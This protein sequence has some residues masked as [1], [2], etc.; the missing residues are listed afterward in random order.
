M[1]FGPWN[2][3]FL[4]RLVNSP[5]IIYSWPWG[6]LG[7]RGIYAR[8]SETFLPVIKPVESHSN[9]IYQGGTG[10]DWRVAFSRL[11]SS[12]RYWA[13]QRRRENTTF[14]SLP[15]P[16]VYTNEDRRCRSIRSIFSPMSDMESKHL[17]SRLFHFLLRVK[18]GLS[19]SPF[20]LSLSR[21]LHFSTVGRWLFPSGERE[22]ERERER[23]LEY[24]ARQNHC[25]PAQPAA[26]VAPRDQPRTQ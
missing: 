10:S 18:G 7:P 9:S 19:T 15:F 8:F 2:L 22:R 12:C 6:K 23:E 13:D 5:F 25:A 11:P 1:G 26:Q 17:R 16:S 3:F 21:H 4:I 20:L 14:Q 24:S